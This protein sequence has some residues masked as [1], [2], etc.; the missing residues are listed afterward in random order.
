MTTTRG[1]L[2]AAQLTG[3]TTAALGRRLTGTERLRG[4]TKKGVYRL[5]LDDG[6]TAIAYVWNADED[7]W[8]D[9][10]SD[11]RLPFGH[12]T[13]LD[14]FTAAHEALSEVGTRVPELYFTGS[15]SHVDG[16]VAVVEDVRGGT[17]ESLVAA[18]RARGTAVLARLGDAVRAAHAARRSEYGRPA[19]PLT[20]PPVPQ[21]VLDRALDHLAESARRVDRIAAVEDRLHAELLARFAAVRPRAE[22]GLIHGELG[23]DHVFVSDAGEAVLIDIEGA[24]YFDVEWE[25]AFLELRFGDDYPALAVP[26]LDP[27]RLR[28]YRLAMYL[29][30]VEGPLRLL[31]G[32]FPHRSGMLAIVEANVA[33][34]LG[35][36]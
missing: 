4:G 29:S 27:D 24:M 11:A 26:G 17:L 16:D 25:H 21:L 2:D 13:A 20:G 3:L 32:D 23:P 10:G 28:F 34:T 22:Y 8:P 31:D 18:D 30:L 6:D 33:R 14:L 15:G 12:A 19:H 1:H 9:T 36:L 5:I 35:Q 7:Y